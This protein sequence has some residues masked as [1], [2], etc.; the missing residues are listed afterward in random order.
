VANSFTAQL[1]WQIVY[2]I[3]V[4]FSHKSWVHMKDWDFLGQIFVVAVG[5]EIGYA[6]VCPSPSNNHASLEN[7][8]LGRRSSERLQDGHLETLNHGFQ[9]EK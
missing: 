8:F 1:E 2:Y 4:K 6:C 9:K 7:G 5:I 3:K